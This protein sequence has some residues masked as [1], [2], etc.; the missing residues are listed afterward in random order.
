MEKILGCLQS[1]FRDLYEGDSDDDPLVECVRRN[2]KEKPTGV[3]TSTPV[4]EK[5]KAKSAT[6]TDLEDE[7]PKPCIKGITKAPLSENFKMLQIE[8]YDTAQIP[9]PI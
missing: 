5:G 6:L 7:D 2:T 3:R 1:K 9:K 8:L 4:H